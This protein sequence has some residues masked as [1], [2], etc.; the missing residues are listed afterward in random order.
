MG[1]DFR[2]V[3][4]QVLERVRPDSAE[5]ARVA[6]AVGK[7][8]RTAKKICH[9]IDRKIKVELVG[10]IAK[11]TWITGAKD[12]DVFLILPAGDYDEEELE[13]EGLPI[14]KRIAGELSAKTELRYAQHPYVTMSF[15]GYDFDL[16]PCLKGPDIISAVDRTPAHTEYV[17]ANLK[18]VDEARL[19]KQ[20]CMG[21]GTYGA[22]M[23]NQAFSG[24]LCEL[25]VIKFGSFCKAM[26][27]ARGWRPPQVRFDLGNDKGIRF[28]APLVFI[29]PVDPNR[30]VASAVSKG[31][32]ERFV[33][34]AS[35][36]LKAPSIEAFFPRE[37]KPLGAIPAKRDMVIVLFQKTNPSASED[38]IYSQLRSLSDHLLRHGL[39][40]FEPRKQEVFADGKTAMAIFEFGK[41]LL[42]KIVV[43]TGPPVG[44]ARKF[45]GA[46]R[47][48]Y[49]KGIFEEEGRLKV[50]LE[51][52]F[53]KPEELLERELKSGIIPKHLGPKYGILSGPA[54]RKFYKKPAPLGAKKFI[55]KFLKKNEETPAWSWK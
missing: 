20:F 6:E 17:K 46:F 35:S 7:V 29:D 47:E 28:S 51:R 53:R 21:A 25:L 31:S 37:A 5:R 43:H 11:D 3:E 39:S 40:E 38:V 54:L 1:L 9:S 42:P 23:K 19:L 14:I 12:I 50:R 30:N 26:N 48:K 55:T 49:G 22:D 16:V 45:T 33:A 27:A 15:S 13:E 4:K 34:A 52:K 8:V 36:Y 32:L 10:S 2:L 24:Y 44:S 41:K 18:N